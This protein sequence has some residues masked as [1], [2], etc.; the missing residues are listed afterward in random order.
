MPLVQAVLAAGAARDRLSY[1]ALRT[2]ADLDPAVAEVVGFTRY[3]IEGDVATSGDGHHRGRRPGRHR[4]ASLPSRTERN[5]RLRG[6]KHRVATER[7]VHGGPRPAATA[8]PCMIVPEVKGDAVPR[9][10]RCCTSRFARP[11][12]GR[13][14][15]ARCSQGYRGRYAAL[16][17]AVT[18]TEPTFRDDLLA[19]IAGGRPAHVSPIT[20]AGR[21]L[22]AADGREAPSVVGIGTDLV[23]VER[24]RLALARTPG[25]R[26]TRLLHRRR[27]GATPS[28]AHGPDR[29]LAARFAA[30]EAV[31]K[32]L[33]VGLG[34][35]ELARDRGGAGRGSGAP[36]LRAARQGRRRWPPTGASP[37]GS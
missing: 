5:P 27:A 26:S 16:R 13:R 7:E 22:S 17:D 33:G 34:A 35:C 25:D 15:R 36:W 21:P 29:A 14:R 19:E 11:P 32:A 18:E 12:A 4:R 28:G 3:R 30:K 10:S 20:L 24:F 2:L 6:T 9:A 37:P 1:R 8:A 23:E 31:M